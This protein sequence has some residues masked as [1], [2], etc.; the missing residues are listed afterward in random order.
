MK[1]LLTFSM[2]VVYWSSC[3]WLFFLFMYYFKKYISSD[4]CMNIHDSF[5]ADLYI[6]VSYQII[7][8]PRGRVCYGLDVT[9]LMNIHDAVCTQCIEC[10]SYYDVFDRE[11]YILK[12]TL[13]C[14]SFMNLCNPDRGCVCDR[15]VCICL[16]SEKKKYADLFFFLFC[17]TKLIFDDLKRIIKSYA[18]CETLCFDCHFV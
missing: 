6:S 4:K 13:M 3:V 1:F 14:V 8:F 17:F 5:D 16:I 11:V 7:R 10:L 9:I 12:K 18:Q 2:P 15:I